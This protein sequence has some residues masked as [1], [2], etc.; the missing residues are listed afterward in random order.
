MF[1]N[2]CRR[3]PVHYCVTNVTMNGRMVDRS[4]LSALECS[5]V[6]KNKTRQKRTKND[7]M[8]IE[9]KATTRYET[10]A[11]RSLHCSES[12]MTSCSYLSAMMVEFQ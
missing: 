6:E 7:T 9:S 8:T 2:L 11:N 10:S 4:L 1:E 12:V 5:V 3:R